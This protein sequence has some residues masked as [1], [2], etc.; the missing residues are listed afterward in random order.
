MREHVYRVNV[1][2]TISGE[3]EERLICA[4]TEKNAYSYST[5]SYE[6]EVVEN[7]EVTTIEFVG[8]LEY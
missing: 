3:V 8:L 6:D 5:V 4:D 2:D 7:L 1:T